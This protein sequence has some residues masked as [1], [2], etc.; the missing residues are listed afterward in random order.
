MCCYIVTA[1][2]LL[3]REGSGGR[4]P[5]GA[6]LLEEGSSDGIDYDNKDGGG[7]NKRGGADD[8]CTSRESGPWKMPG[9]NDGGKDGGGER[10]T[11][12]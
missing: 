3:G 4:G 12:Q 6:A 9:N 10:W 11:E 8:D 1:A 2:A 7:R 5:V